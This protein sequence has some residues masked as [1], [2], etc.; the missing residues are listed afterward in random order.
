MTILYATIALIAILG[1]L[2][3]LF[4]PIQ[5]HITTETKRSSLRPAERESRETWTQEEWLRIKEREIFPPKD[6]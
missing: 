1:L 2:R 5:V 6:E 3:A 4:W